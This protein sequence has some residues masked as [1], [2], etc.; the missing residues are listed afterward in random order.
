M[1]PRRLHI[2]RVVASDAVHVTV[3]DRV[4]QPVPT[5]LDRAFLFTINGIAV[6]PSDT[7]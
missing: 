4:R 5:D 2:V 1:H 7:G 6:G 3:D